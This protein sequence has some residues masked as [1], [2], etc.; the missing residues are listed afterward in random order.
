MKCNS[1]L[2]ARYRPATLTLQAAPVAT[3]ELPPHVSTPSKPSCLITKWGAIWLMQISNSERSHV[4]HPIDGCESKDGSHKLPL[5][6]SLRQS[7]RGEP[8]TRIVPGHRVRERQGCARR[9]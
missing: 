7:T 5:G 3:V 4:Q 1:C 2:G 9:G 6:I 8:R